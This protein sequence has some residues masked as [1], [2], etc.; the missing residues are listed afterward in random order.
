MK[1]LK[2][3]LIL[4]IMTSAFAQEE[5]L[6]FPISYDR[7]DVSVGILRERGPVIANVDSDPQLEIIVLSDISPADGRSNQI[8]VYDPLN[9]ATPEYTFD[10]PTDLDNDTLRFSHSPAV[11]DGDGDG[12]MEI[13]V[14]AW[15]VTQYTSGNPV[16]QLRCPYRNFT[17]GHPGLVNPPTICSH[18]ISKVLLYEIGNPTPTRLDFTSEAKF[19]QPAVADVTGDGLDDIVFIGRQQEGWIDYFVTG[20]TSWSN[21]IVVFTYNVQS[22]A[23]TNTFFSFGFCHRSTDWGLPTINESTVALG[24]IREHDGVSDI[25]ALLPDA[26]PNGFAKLV[27]VEYYNG[28]RIH[29]VVLTDKYIMESTIPGGILGYPG[30]ILGDIIGDG[31]LDAAFIILDD[32]ADMSSQQV[33]I[34][35]GSTND[36]QYIDLPEGFIFSQRD[37]MAIADGP[38]E[39]DHLDIYIPTRND[40]ILRMQW[41]RWDQNQFV[42]V[43]ANDPFRGWPKTFNATEAVLGVGYAPAIFSTSTNGALD[44][45]TRVGAG[46]NSNIQV[47][48]L[49]D[50]EGNDLSI[51]IPS[52]AGSI[53]LG[54]AT[55]TDLNQDGHPE[56]IATADA[57]YTSGIIHAF[58]YEDAT[59]DSRRDQWNGL[60][61]G[62]KH[63]GLYANSASGEQIADTARWSGRVIV[64]DDFSVPYRSTLTL[65]PGTLV[66]VESD[67]SFTVYGTIIANG[68]T[69]QPVTFAAKTPGETWPGLKIETANANLKH[70]NI[71]DTW[72]YGLF[73]DGS[74]SLCSLDHVDIDCSTLDLGAAGLLIWNQN[75]FSQY[76]KN[77]RVH[78]ANPDM[79]NAGMYLYNCKV[80]FDSVTIEDC[81]WVNSYIKKVTGSFRA[82][83]FRDRTENYA[84]FFNTIP[85][86]PNFRCC[87]FTNLAPLNG[88]YPTTIYCVT[89][90]MPTF[91]AEGFTGGNGVSNVITDSSAYLLT[92]TGS[93]NLPVVD[94]YSPYQIETNG[95][96]NDWIQ[97][98]QAGRF[99]L[100]NNP[101]ATTYPCTEQ[102][103]SPPVSNNLF[104]PTTATLWD[105]DPW[106]NT[107]WEVC[108]GAGGGV[109]GDSY[110]DGPL[111]RGEDD[112]LDDNEF[113]SVLLDALAFEEAEDYAAAQELF[114][115]VA[116]NTSES[117][118]RWF[119]LTHVVVCESFTLGGA[120]WFGE[121]LDDMIELEDSYESRVLGERLRTSLYQ[122]RNE[123][124]DA[125]MTCAALLSSGLTYEDSIYVA[126][127]LVGLQLGAGEGGGSL[128]GMSATELIP[129]A[130]RAS[131]DSEALRIER[132]LFA[133]LNPA[134][135]ESR[136]TSSVPT[137]FSLAQNYPNPFNPTTQ[138]EYDLPEAVRVTLKVF[139][140]LGQE[141]A[142]VHDALMP[143]GH[144]VTTWDG[145]SSAGADVATGLYIY[146]LKAG[147]FQDA[148]KMML[149]R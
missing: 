105:F 75:S 39:S 87:E 32:P 13:A 8:L 37:I 70:V 47:L 41:L 121:L 76:V 81:D 141:V 20:G 44:F 97:N 86:T 5:F 16:E 58:T 36:V 142:V 126:M 145:K 96:K 65:D 112:R 122:N 149:L 143:A 99:F 111:A 30:P 54:A 91:G 113:D 56:L 29:N 45:V 107:A 1:S 147:S 102:Y 139:N 19:A 42:F 146:Q 77:T 9:P 35:D 119:A 50:A 71:R 67:A 79:Q 131:D 63:S 23:W 124:D 14:G 94:S 134:V 73:V 11:L 10:M 18:V 90:T 51:Q 84:V 6:N 140:T 72:E 114:R 43:Q 132:D 38:T 48:K 116:G 80:D 138:I 89:G 148:K 4:C 3:W 33:A 49:N 52:G 100:R 118:Q 40:T 85:N 103:W 26:S 15:K 12:I 64:R 110:H 128:D 106:Q 82:C 34:F 61:N 120:A 95:G 68:T 24:D 109:G 98:M 123:Y 31:S 17:C 115:Y 108:G 133:Q 104:T 28:Q 69:A 135:D 144:H 66:L 93:I 78:S 53:Y 130:L 137:E 129:T 62:S 55:W 136:E 127:D 46:A 92:M 22:Q 117:S 59:Y 83:T 74:D 2:V 60:L 27:I 25:V 125:I 21:A 88:N 101:G 7:T 57:D